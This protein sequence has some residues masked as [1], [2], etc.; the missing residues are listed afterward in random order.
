MSILATRRALLALLL[1]TLAIFA[2][3]SDGRADLTVDQGYD[4]LH[5]LPGTSFMGVDFKGVPYGTFDFG[6][7]FGVQNVGNA[8]TIVHR[9]SDATVPAP[10]MSAAIDTELVGLQLESTAPTDFGLG[11]V[12]RRI[13]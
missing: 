13:L 1:G 9:L 11:L 7:P 3:P 5:T 8:D 10:G 2:S 12:L 4:L 6:A